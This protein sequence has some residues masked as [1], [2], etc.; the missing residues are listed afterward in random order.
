MKTKNQNRDIIDEQVNTVPVNIESLIKSAGIE[1][2]KMLCKA[3]LDR[4]LTEIILERFETK[5]GF[6]KY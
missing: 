4:V 2:N 3:K 5:T 1:L 6:T